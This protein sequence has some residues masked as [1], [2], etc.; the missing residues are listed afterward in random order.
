MRG[1]DSMAIGFLRRSNRLSRNIWEA[2]LEEGSFELGLKDG[3]TLDDRWTL[4]WKGE[5]RRAPRAE[6]WRWESPRQVVKLGS[7]LAGAEGQVGVGD[8]DWHLLSICLVSGTVSGPLPAS[9]QHAG[10]EIDILT[11]R[12]FED[13]SFSPPHLYLGPVHLRVKVSQ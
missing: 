12:L 13:I 2:F 8:E 3:W 7:D 5:S 9:S 10:R 4:D 11:K 6:A 1:A